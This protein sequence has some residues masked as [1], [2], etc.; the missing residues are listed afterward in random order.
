MPMELSEKKKML[1]FA[2]YARKVSK[3]ATF[4]ILMTVD[5]DDE[6]D[7]LTWYM[8]QHPNASEEELYAVARQLDKESR[9]KGLK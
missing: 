4:H 2:L 7:D 5:L 6:I 9:E 8:G 3:D 1:G